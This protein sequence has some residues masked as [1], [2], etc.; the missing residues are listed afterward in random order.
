MFPIQEVGQRGGRLG[1]DL[2][3]TRQG[4]RGKSASWFWF[5]ALP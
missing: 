4:M 3:S 5:E 2:P 1:P